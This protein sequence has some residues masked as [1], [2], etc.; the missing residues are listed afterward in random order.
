LRCD[1]QRLYVTLTDG[2]EISAPLT[3]KLQRA[4]PQQRKGGRVADFGTALRWDEIDEDLSVA[5]LLGVSE[6]ELESL[7]GFEPTASRAPGR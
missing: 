6:G 3:L 7:A 4:T 1:E 5:A 2:R